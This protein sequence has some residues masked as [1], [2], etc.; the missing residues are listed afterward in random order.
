MSDNEH[1]TAPLWDSPKL[2]IQH[3]P[4]CA[5]PEVG[6]VSKN[7]SH[8]SRDKACKSFLWFAIFCENRMPFFVLNG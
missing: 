8:G 5:I 2:S 6:Q 3:S 7:A 4:L 1:A